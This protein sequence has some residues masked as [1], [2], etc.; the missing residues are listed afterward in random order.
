[1]V[2]RPHRSATMVGVRV[3]FSTTAGAGH[4]GPLVPFARA[5]AAAGHQV[6]VAAPATFAEQV[7]RAGFDHLPFADVPPE[8]L[9]DVFSRV[10]QLSR[11]EGNRVVITEVFARLDAQAALPR[12]KALMTEW[13]P[14]IVLRETCEFASMVAASRAG[15]PQVHVAIGMGRLGAMGEMLAEPLAELSALAGLSTARGQELLA[16]TA[17]FTSVPEVLDREDG[18]STDLPGPTGDQESRV[19]RFRE[20]GAPGFGQ[21]PT[22]WGRLA[23]PLLY[24]TY[25][26]VTATVARFGSVYGDTLRALADLP[27]RVLMTTGEGLDSATLEPVPG[28]ARVERWW[29]QAD[30]MPL[31]A[32]V[33]GHGGFG[34][35]MAALTAGVPQVVVPLFAYDQFVNADRVAG[36]GAGVQLVGGPGAIDQLPSAVEK[37]LGEPTYREG[38]RAVAA[39]IAALP[40][41]ATCP[42]VLEGLAGR[43]R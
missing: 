7:A 8:V 41:V 10:A 17:T 12:L 32:A 36:A 18:R 19:W 15:I 21:L 2:T 1:M 42:T 30:V 38:A 33:V 24:V 29:P 14:D 25:G 22:S 39:E 20:G 13:A 40:D 28:N 4:F 26:S 37:L 16:G 5:C 35:T 11:E 34:T 3:L 27:V 43:R 23:D 31:A 9:G 6:A